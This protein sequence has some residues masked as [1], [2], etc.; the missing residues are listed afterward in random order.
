MPGSNKKRKRKTSEDELLRA[1]E[2]ENLINRPRSDVAIQMQ[3]VVAR[4]QRL[5]K[6]ASTVKQPEEHR[7]DH[8]LRN[9][10]RDEKEQRLHERQEAEL[11][12]LS[13]ILGELRR[14][15]AQAQIGL[16]RQNQNKR[17]LEG[18]VAVKNKGHAD[19]L[20]NM[21]DTRAM[22]VQ[23]QSS[24]RKK[25]MATE[26]IREQMEAANHLREALEKELE[27]EIIAR[28]QAITD[29]A[30]AG[31]D[32]RTAGDDYD[33]LIAQSSA[34]EEELQLQLDAL[35]ET[36]AEL[37]AALR[38]AFNE[39]LTKIVEE[40]KR[41]F[42]QDNAEGMR[43]LKQRYTIKWTEYDSQLA[44]IEAQNTDLKNQLS[45]LNAQ[46]RRAMARNE[47]A[48]RLEAAVKEVNRLR[49]CIT[50]ANDRWARSSAKNKAK[51]EQLRATVNK[52]D[53]EY[54]DLMD[55]KVALAMEIK[56]YSGLLENEED[57]LGYV[58]PVKR[59]RDRILEEVRSHRMD[60]GA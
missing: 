10:E 22:L 43:E 38:N 17:T 32:K 9:A 23:Y 46:I 37:E 21:S 11:E 47:P 57:R 60:E 20:R 49:G 33:L 13:N 41:Q 24:D 59:A 14:D 5:V 51:L 19:V 30:H 40:R 25:T 36:P 52:K 2:R 34:E 50:A 29:A 56:A 45:D 7:E 48:I 39:Q 53:R 35:K 42:A 18:H 28:D 6:R 27:R 55:L 4:M 54:D 26:K 58:S 31:I 1:R 12:R 8:A 16:D 3:E 15:T 44:D